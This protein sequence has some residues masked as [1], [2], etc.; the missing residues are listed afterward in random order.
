MSLIIFQVYFTDDFQIIDKSDEIVTNLLDAPFPQ[1]ILPK[2][3]SLCHPYLIISLFWSKALAP[4]VRR[5]FF[6]AAF[7]WKKQF[8]SL[9][10]RL[11]EVPLDWF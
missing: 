5:E 8:L 11:T 3:V 7:L 10:V 2:F 6:F 1:K 9:L 4:I